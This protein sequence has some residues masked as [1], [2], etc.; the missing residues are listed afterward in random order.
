MDRRAEVI[1][2]RIRREGDRAYWRG[3]ARLIEE[4][5][6]E[7]EQKK[8]EREERE[9]MSIQ[10]HIANIH[11]TRQS[12]AGWYREF[13]LDPLNAELHEI[14]ADENLSAAG[15]YKKEDDVKAKYSKNV[16]TFAAETH[17]HLAN[18]YAAITDK[19]RQILD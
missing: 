5:R 6:K 14:K 7:A 10:A 15:R 4:A 12:M 18:E 8:Q 16:L 2:A 11:N 9:R 17:K 1:N 3:Q 19:A 13:Y